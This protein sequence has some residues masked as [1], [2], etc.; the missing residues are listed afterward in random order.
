V[1]RSSAADI[2]HLRSDHAHTH[3]YYDRTRQLL[4]RVYT[5]LNNLIDCSINRTVDVGSLIY[6]VDR[7]IRESLKYYAIMQICVFQNTKGVFT[8]VGGLKNSTS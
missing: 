8:N 6:G 2:T 3:L 7:S 1:Q 5:D 4:Q